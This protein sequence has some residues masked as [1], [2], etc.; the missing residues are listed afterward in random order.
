MDSMD[1]IAILMAGLRRSVGTPWFELFEESLGRVFCAVGGATPS[2]QRF[3][4]KPT[5]P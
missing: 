3:E 2:F 4:K 5:C 1:V